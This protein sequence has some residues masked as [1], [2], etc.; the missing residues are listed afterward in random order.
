M[1]LLTGHPPKPISAEQLIQ[2]LFAHETRQAAEDSLVALGASA[3]PVITVL[4]TSQAL[5][6]QL[7]LAIIL[8]KIGHVG[9]IPV[10][11][12]VL[13]DNEPANVRVRMAAIRAL[14]RIGGIECLDIVEEFRTSANHVLRRTALEV[15]EQLRKQL[16]MTIEEAEAAELQPDEPEVGLAVAVQTDP[17]NYGL[18]KLSPELVVEIITEV[19]QRD[20]QINRFELVKLVSRRFGRGYLIR[21]RQ[22]V[23]RY[24]YPASAR[25]DL[26]IQ[27]DLVIA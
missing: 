25:G 11:A 22:Y 19:L 6:T 3:V 10:L 14:G 21:V 16:T 20:R 17:I 4:F 27:D 5:G 26:R 15:A 24:I 8:G 7:R 2:Q 12:E 9:A 13:Q 1:H 23:N 18:D